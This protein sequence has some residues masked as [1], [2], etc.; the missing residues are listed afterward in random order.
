VSARKPALISSEIVPLCGGSNNPK[1]HETISALSSN[2]IKILIS[3]Q[4][5][6]GRETVVVPFRFDDILRI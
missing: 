2:D 3:K 4:K 5:P 6:D 1:R